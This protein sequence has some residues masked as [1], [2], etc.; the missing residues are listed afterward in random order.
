MPEGYVPKPIPFFNKPLE[1][2]LKL[3]WAMAP[4]GADHPGE[5]WCGTMPGGLF[6]S[7]EQRRVLGTESA[8]VG[9][10]ETRR[11]G[12]QWRRMARASI[13][14]AWIRGIQGMSASAYSTGGVW[15]TRDSGNSWTP[16]GGGMRAE[17]SARTAG[18]SERSGRALP[19]AMRV[20]S[21]DVLGSTSQRHL[22]VDR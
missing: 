18:R 20:E 3:I 21:G 12:A 16:T 5:V 13:R 15:I 1:W 2:S 4:G 17:S 6:K 14:S 8:V 19:G 7:G 11:V 22:Q 9:S 10:P